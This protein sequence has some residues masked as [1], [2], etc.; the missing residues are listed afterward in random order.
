[1]K[2]FL[3]GLLVLLLIVGGGFAALV[4]MADAGAPETE[5]IRIEVSD[6][7]RGQD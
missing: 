1:M 5:E 6:E 4:A 3:I 7:L 2:G